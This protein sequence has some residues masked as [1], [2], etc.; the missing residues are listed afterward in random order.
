MKRIGIMGGTFN[1]IHNGHLAIAKA[2]YQQFSLEKVLFL[3]SKKPPHKKNLKLAADQSRTDMVKLAIAPYPFFEFSGVEMGRE[4]YSYTADTL[5]LLKAEYPDFELC[6]IIGADSLHDM[7]DWY[8]PQRIFD[9]SHILCAPRYPNTEEEDYQCCEELVRQ[10]GAVIDFI[11]ME[12]INLSSKRFLQDFQVG[13]AVQDQV[14]EDVYAYI[15][16]HGLYQEEGRNTEELL[17]ILEKELPKKRYLHTIGVADVASCLSMRYGEDMKKARLAGLLH[18]CA[19]CLPDQEIYE[20][21]RQAGI[22]ISEVEKRQPFL[23]HAKLGAFYARTRFGIVDDE[24]LTAITYHTTG[25]PNMSRLEKIIFLADYIE[26]GRKEIP[27]L[28]RIRELAFYDLDQAVYLTLE[29]TLSYLKGQNNDKKEIDRMTINAYNYY[30]EKV[31]R[32]T[33]E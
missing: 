4:G 12:P 26:P 21:S 31:E 29:N 16:K 9:V 32:G 10:Y 11:E 19:K 23:L 30:K 14:P 33:E 18:D 17:E 2:A 22:E 7:R 5:K 6:F 1:P 27:G 13:R 3:P 15:R 28:L 25:R 24:I 8:E 20:C